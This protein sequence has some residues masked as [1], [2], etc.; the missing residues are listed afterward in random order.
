MYLPSADEGLTVSIMGWAPI[1]DEKCIWG[2]DK[3][4]LTEGKDGTLWRFG[5]WWLLVASTTGMYK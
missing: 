5:E 4:L 3:A 1:G 2:S